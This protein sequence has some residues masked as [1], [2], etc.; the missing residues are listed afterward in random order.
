MCVC[1]CAR[2][3]GGGGL[4][5]WALLQDTPPHTLC[6]VAVCV[7][8]SA[9]FLPLGRQNSWHAKPHITCNMVNTAIR[10]LENM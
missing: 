10:S 4:I 2:V 1:V 6:P 9:S 5:V 8:L 7:C 3:W